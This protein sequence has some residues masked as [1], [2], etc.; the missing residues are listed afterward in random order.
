MKDAELGSKDTTDVTTTSAGSTSSTLE[1]QVTETFF[2]FTEERV[3][4]PAHA[5]LANMGGVRVKTRDD[6]QS[7]PAQTYIVTGKHLGEIYFDPDYSPMDHLVIDKEEISDKS[8]SDAF[9]KAIAVGQ[10]LWLICQMITRRAKHLLTSQLEI[11]TLAFGTLAIV[12]YGAYWDK[13]QN[14]ENPTTIYLETFSDDPERDRRIRAALQP[15]K[16]TSFFR[17]VLWH[18]EIF[19]ENRS[20]YTRVPNDNFA[21]NLLPDCLMCLVF[22]TVFFGGL[23]CVAWD[24]RFP[25]H[26]ELVMWRTTSVMT[27][28]MPALIFGSQ[29]AV[30]WSKKGT[31]KPGYSNND[32]AVHPVHSMI[33]TF[34]YGAYV[35]GR[36]TLIA[37]AVA[38]LRRM[39]ADVYVST[40]AKYLPSVQ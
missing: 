24:F 18:S 33:I 37:L 16:S 30:T 8:D 15:P 25:T 22:V 9:A 34:G 26:V 6:G 10:L 19:R 32:L 4:T 17:R 40:W 31:F 1:K 36:L 20:H 39:P 23:H 7:G 3:W 14:I 29:Y 28:V 35:L 27:T 12:I 38:S 2:P 13:P 11:V 21:F 5:Y